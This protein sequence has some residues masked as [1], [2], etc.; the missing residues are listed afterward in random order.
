MFRDTQIVIF[1][2]FVVVPNVGIKRADYNIRATA[3]QTYNSAISK[4]SDQPAHPR[5]L[6]RVFA[7]HICLLQTL[8]YPKSLLSEFI[9]GNESLLVTPIS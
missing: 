6:I 1:T 3:R 8:G 2:N 4:D 9:G 7:D 5:N